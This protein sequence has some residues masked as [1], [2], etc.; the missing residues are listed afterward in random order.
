MGSFDAMTMG[1]RLKLDLNRFEEI[2]MIAF[3]RR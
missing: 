2:A 1:F 3:N